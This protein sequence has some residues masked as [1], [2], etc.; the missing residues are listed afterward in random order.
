MSPP[1]PIDHQVPYE[2]G[3]YR[4]CVRM[5]RDQ[6]QSLA[7]HVVSRD[8]MW[9]LSLSGDDGHHNDKLKVVMGVRTLMK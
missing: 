1:L 9:E 2:S 7:R 4:F 5:S 8:V 6:G 3:D